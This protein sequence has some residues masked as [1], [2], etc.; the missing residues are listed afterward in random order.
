VTNPKGLVVLHHGFSE[1]CGRYADLIGALNQARYSVASFDM[2][3][4]GRSEGRRGH[5]P[6][7]R[8]L[9]DDYALI[10]ANAQKE[11]PGI[12]TFLYG[13]SM[14][15]TVVLQFA[16]R[17]PEGLT[18]AIIASPFL[19]LVFAPP[20]WKVTLGRLMARVWGGFSL[21]AGIEFDAF[22]RVPAIVAIARADPLMHGIMSAAF[23][24]G[25]T[26]AARDA[27]A[28]ASNLRLPT[29]L[30]HGKGDRITDWRA[31]EWFAQRAGTNATFRPYE[32]AFH[33]L[34]NDLGREVFFRDVVGWLDSCV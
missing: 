28:C 10:L 19:R 9:L 30:A 13:H 34:H 16:L 3:G 8:V 6:N 4:H 14:G 1:H 7:F 5:A 32:G 31:S 17:H 33:E 21:H 27:L 15:G 2:R 25:M 12:N 11:W 18:G 26:N 24:A 23:Y 20:P 22:S 29:L